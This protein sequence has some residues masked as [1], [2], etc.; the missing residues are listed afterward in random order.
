MSFSKTRAV[1]A[2]TLVLTVAF[3]LA[4]LPGSPPDQ[5]Q[6]EETGTWQD[7]VLL[8]A[9]DTKGKIEPCG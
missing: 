3:G 6:A 5:A 7:L 9:S 4:V 8:Y 2:V 1:S